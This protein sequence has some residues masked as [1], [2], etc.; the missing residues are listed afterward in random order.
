M[1]TADSVVEYEAYVE[2]AEE[3]SV[4]GGSGAVKEGVCHTFY[5]L[6]AAF[7]GVLILAVWFALPRIDDQGT[8][9]L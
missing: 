3:P 4:C 6:E 9:V 8:E 5:G 2:E 7:G 1:G